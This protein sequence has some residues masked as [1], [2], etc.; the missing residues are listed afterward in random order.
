MALIAAWI[1]WCIHCS[2]ARAIAAI[3]RNGGVVHLNRHR[4]EVSITFISGARMPS[5]LYCEPIEVTRQ[6]INDSPDR[7]YWLSECLLGTRHNRI[8]VVEIPIG[9]LTPELL[10]CLASL[11]DLDEIV[12]GLPRHMVAKDST[13][14]R[15]LLALQVRLGNKLWWCHESQLSP[16]HRDVSVLREARRFPAET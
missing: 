8:R 11:E 1:S 7:T 6:A 10:R 5:Y 16:R 4:P 9:R 14:G 15:L 13:L 3:E 12:L 2:D